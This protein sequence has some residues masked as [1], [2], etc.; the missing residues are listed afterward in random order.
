VTEDDEQQ[1]R[2]ALVAILGN[3]AAPVP[4]TRLGGLTNRVFQAGEMVLRL[5]GAGTE[6]YI[7]RAAEAVAA[8][9]AAAAGSPPR[10][11]P[12]T[13]PPASCLPGSSPGPPP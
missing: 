3:G 9:A 1:A 7:D 4:L 2:A 10:C 11:W 8:R 12:M 5:P 13:R 6:A